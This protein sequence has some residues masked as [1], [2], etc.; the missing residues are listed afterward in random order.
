MALSEF[1]L[2]RRY[3]TS[4]QQG[5]AVVTGIGD[6]CA[7]LAL[8]PGHT[9]FTSIDT[10]VEGVHFPKN[11]D[12]NG[13]GWRVLAAAVSDLGACG[14]KPLGF[15]LALTLPEADERWLSD[16]AE[17]LAEA[18]QHFSI[19][20]VGGD[21]T[22]G[23]LCLSVQVFGEAPAGKA[24]LRSG[25][26]VGDDLWVTGTL[27]DARAALDV[28]EKKNP[29]GSERH[30]LQQYYRAEPPLS[31][32]VGLQ[33]VASSAIDLSDGLAADLGHI[34]QA[35][36]VG[37]ELDLESLPLS[38]ALMS[39]YSAEQAQYYALTGGDDYQL[40]FSASVEQRE[41][42]SDL[43]RTEKLRCTRVG[44]ITG[45]GELAVKRGSIDVDLNAY[46]NKGYQ[47]FS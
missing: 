29:A 43:A 8:S 36:K 26:K 15:C 12:V 32:A 7:E 18:S 44:T 47:H 5:P 42:I 4:F 17:G 21:T 6:D 28:L 39:S 30:F 16:F 13:L 2:I 24:L 35:S 40:C 14:A 3:F 31:F 10:M 1:D 45:S 34:L 46:K 33:G 27:G 37:A 22:R 19:P 38:D 9:L 11:P 20:L 25:A 41:L 23:P